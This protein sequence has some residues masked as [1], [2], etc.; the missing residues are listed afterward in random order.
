MFCFSSYCFANFLLAILAKEFAGNGITVNAIAP[1]FIETDMVR[2][3]RGDVMEKLLAQIP[4]RRLGKAS[5]VAG[6][7][8]YLASQD[9]DYITGQVI[10]INGGVYI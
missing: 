10:D 5:E 3:V 6:T 7:V 9:G 2:G 1:G 8:A 4:L